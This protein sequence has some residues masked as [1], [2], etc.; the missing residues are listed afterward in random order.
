MTQNCVH[1]KEGQSDC[2]EAMPISQFLYKAFLFPTDFP[3]KGK[4]AIYPLYM[5][6]NC[7]EDDHP[8]KNRTFFQ[9]MSFNRPNTF[10]Y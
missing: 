3:L 8:F 1:I 5:V 9:Y 2:L 6:D 10:L 4:F 7:V